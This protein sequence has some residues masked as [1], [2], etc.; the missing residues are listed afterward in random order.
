MTAR[1]TSIEPPRMCRKDDP[2]DSKLPGDELHIIAALREMPQLKGRLEFDE[3]AQRVGFS[4]EPPWRRR[5][6]GWTDCDTTEL[7]AFL[8]E[9]GYRVRSRAV[10]DAA[11]QVVARDRIVHP[12]CQFLEACKAVYDGTPRLATLFPDYFDAQGDAAYLQAIGGKFLISAV[13]RVFAPGCKV[14]TLPVLEARQG[15]GKSRAVRIIGEP[16]IT[17]SLPSLAD[18]REAAMALRGVWIAEVA[19]LAAMTRAET[20]H[21]KAFISRQVDDVREPYQRHTTRL[22]RQTVMIGTT[23]DSTYLRDGTGGRRFWPVRCGLIDLEMLARDRMQLLGEAVLA[24]EAG[25]PWH[26]DRDAERLAASEQE[27]R[28]Y[29]T[30]LETTLLEYLDQR[31]AAGTHE[32]DM[33]D[34]IRTV[35]NLDSADDQRRA[36]A[37]GAQ[38]ASLLAQN[39]WRQARVTGRGSR[40]RNIWTCID[41]PRMP[42]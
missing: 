11:V 20:E 1:A 4:S 22:L 34:A 15:A 35:C 13:A 14:D 6:D 7:A 32:I 10:V 33:R 31:T 25:T 19:E 24:Y 39:G 36:A 38:L 5:G 2:R 28:R 18:S 40:R 42:Q 12:V 9:N 30:E 8:Q 37:Y 16:W 21:V 26:L 29:R 17:E 27:A 41:A 3:F 23:N